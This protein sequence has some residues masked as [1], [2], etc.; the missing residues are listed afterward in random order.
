MNTLE[1]RNVLKLSN[2]YNKRIKKGLTIANP[3]NH[4]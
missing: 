3:H 2:L 1:N 4:F